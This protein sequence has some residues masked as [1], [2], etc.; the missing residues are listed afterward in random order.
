MNIAGPG[1]D[2]AVTG[3]Q[4]GIAVPPQL[5]PVHKK[6]AQRR[7]TDPAGQ[8]AHQPTVFANRRRHNDHLVAVVSAGDDVSHR[9]LSVY[10]PPEVVSVG[11]VEI[12]IPGNGHHFARQISNKE[13]VVMGVSAIEA[14]KVVHSPQS[15][16]SAIVTV[17]GEGFHQNL[18]GAPGGEVL[19][20]G[21]HPIVHQPDGKIDLPDQTVAG[22]LLNGPGGTEIEIEDKADHASEHDQKN[23]DEQFFPDTEV[24]AYFTTSTAFRM[25]R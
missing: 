21:R 15:G 14:P 19:L 5:E 2:P 22:C 17:L 8:N 12:G 25:T 7:Q 11:D 24:H 9:R 18:L 10:G 23:G 4:K 1:D 13:Q 20:A 16:T 6:S 3:S